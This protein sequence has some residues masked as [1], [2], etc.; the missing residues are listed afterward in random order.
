M[1]NWIPLHYCYG[2]IQLSFKLLMTESVSFHNSVLVVPLILNFVFYFMLYRSL[3]LIW[4]PYI[5]DYILAQF[6]SSFHWII[7]LKRIS[8]SLN[9]CSLGLSLAITQSTENNIVLFIS[10]DT[11]PS[12]LSIQISFILNRWNDLEQFPKQ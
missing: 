12:L 7:F 1:V 3:I 4:F 5:F 2:E 11:F 8:L 10:M 6:L 9:P